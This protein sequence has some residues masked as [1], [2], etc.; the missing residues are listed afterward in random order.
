M[1]KKVQTSIVRIQY[2]QESRTRSTWGHPSGLRRFVIGAE[3]QPS[4]D[5]LAETRLSFS[6]LDPL[7]ASLC[8]RAIPSAARPGQLLLVK[9]RKTAFFDDELLHVELATTAEVRS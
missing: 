6:T 9:H 1:D 5:T 2:V 3:R 7:K 4:G 8:Q